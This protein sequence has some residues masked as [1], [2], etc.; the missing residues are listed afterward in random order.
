MSKTRRYSTLLAIFVASS[1][2][3]GMGA[4]KTNEVVLASF[5][6]RGTEMASKVQDKR[7]LDDKKWD[8]TR[9]PI[10]LDPKRAFEIAAPWARKQGKD[11]KLLRMGI[12]ALGAHDKKF[13]GHFYYNVEFVINDGFHAP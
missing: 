5:N 3:A 12:V 11:A 7:L 4:E 9:D 1:L 6:I 2:P 8:L 10:P 13:E